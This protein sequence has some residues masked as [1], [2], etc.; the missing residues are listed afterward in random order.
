MAAPFISPNARRRASGIIPGWL[1][2][3]GLLHLALIPAARGDVSPTNTPFPG[4]I[5]YSETRPE[6]PTRTFVAE[7]DLTRPHLRVRVAPGG[8]DPDGPGPWET[9][10][11]EPT[12]IAAREGMVLVFNGDFFEARQV[13]DAEGTHSGYRAG[14]WGAAVGPA[15]TDGKAWSLGTQS[16][17]CLVV[18]KN[19]KI[20]LEMVS[21][22]TADD[23]EVVAG[24]TMLIQDGIAVPH[25]NKARHPRTAVGLNAAGTKLTVLVVDGRKPGRAVGMRYDELAAEMLRLGCR[26]ALNLDGGGSSVMAFRD[27]ATGMFHI[28]NEP[29]DGR[30]RAVANAVGISVDNSEAAARRQNQP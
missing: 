18:H 29:T 22:P 23:W 14:I 20:T 21:Q 10:L 27:P 25:Q 19:R 2:T 5:C 7:V 3:F 4:I 28:L 24:N 16:K 26:Q 6:P 1:L 17:P 9:T 15:V 13:K 12:R 11:L 30:E 8:P